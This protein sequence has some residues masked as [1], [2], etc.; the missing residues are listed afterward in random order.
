MLPIPSIFLIPLSSRLPSSAGDDATSAVGS[1]A[2]S[3]SEARRSEADRR[4]LREAVA[5]AADLDNYQYPG[6]VGRAEL[7]GIL[8]ITGSMD[9][10]AERAVAAKARGERST[11]EGWDEDPPSASAPTALAQVS[12]QQRQARVAA[13]N[14]PRGRA[15]AGKGAG[16][17]SAGAGGGTRGGGEEEGGCVLV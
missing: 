17:G 1:V 15:D 14:A 3:A 8:G 4:A 13:R 5:A 2:T 11:D 7:E 9:V 12:A 16:G 6:S 10:E